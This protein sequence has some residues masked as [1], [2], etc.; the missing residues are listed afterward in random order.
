MATAVIATVGWGASLKFLA[1]LI[2]DAEEKA[3]VEAALN[4]ESE[5]ELTARVDLGGLTTEVLEWVQA[6]DHVQFRVEH[7]K[8]I[9]FF[10][11]TGYKAVPV[12]SALQAHHASSA[13]KQASAFLDFCFQRGLLE[14]ADFA[15][16]TADRGVHVLVRTLAPARMIKIEALWTNHGRAKKRAAER[17][18]A[19]RAKK[20]ATERELAGAVMKPEECE[21]TGD[22]GKDEAAAPVGAKK[23]PKDSGMDVTTVYL[24]PKLGFLGGCDIDGILKQQ[25]VGTLVE[26]VDGAYKVKTSSEKLQKIRDVFADIADVEEQNAAKGSVARTFAQQRAEQEREAE[27]EALHP[28]EQLQAMQ[29]FASRADDPVMRALAEGLQTSSRRRELLIT[30]GEVVRA[31]KKRR[32][33]EAASELKEEEEEEDGAMA[34]AV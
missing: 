32:R 26:K 24:R 33:D 13:H 30:R 15:D 34:Q 6:C 9:V 11:A 21:E 4:R 1:D 12:M 22:K 27:K 25:E 5:S 8:L 2:G 10:L 3:L 19:G 18:L 16:K 23:E 29:V 20:E 31:D 14:Q 17:D 7:K 28:R